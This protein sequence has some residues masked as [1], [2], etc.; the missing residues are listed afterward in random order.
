M[1]MMIAR[2]QAGSTRGLAV[3]AWGA[4]NAQSHNHNDVGNLVV[5]ADG[6][7]VFV[8]LGAPTYT[9][10]TFSSRRYDIPAMQSDWH[11][12]PTIND[13]AQAAGLRFAA[14][15]V[16]HRATDAMAEVSMDLAPAWPPEARVERWRRTV[17]LTRG[18]D[19]TVTEDFRLTETRGATRLNLITPRTPDLSEPGRIRLPP[20]P[21]TGAGARALIVRFDAGRLEAVAEPF[22]LAD[23]RLESTWGPRLVRLRITARS[24]RPEDRWELRMELEP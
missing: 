1:Q 13:T 7:P 19:L 11:N 14:R 16:T 15:D 9:A 20:L 22:D 18:S 21:G 6:Q 4:H 10:K 24:P 3:A 8:D 2:D 12:L 23:R 17:R 5:F